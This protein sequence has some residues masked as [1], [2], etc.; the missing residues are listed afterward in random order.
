MSWTPR[1]T[2]TLIVL[3]VVGWSLVLLAFWNSG[4]FTG[5]LIEWDIQPIHQRQHQV[6]IN[7][8]TQRD[9]ELL[10]GIG[11]VTAR[12]IVESRSDHGAF[13]TVE[14]LDR[15]HGIGKKTIEKLRKFLTINR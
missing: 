5:Q 7:R 14:D 2:N 9:F 4:G 3:A 15:V 8:A 10:P 6:D 1:E 13:T 12:K 11:P